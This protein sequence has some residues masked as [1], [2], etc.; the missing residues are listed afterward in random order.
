MVTSVLK[1]DREQIERA[2][3]NII[4]NAIESMSKEGKL[5]IFTEHNGAS[6]VIKI[7]D[8]GKGISEEDIIKI[9]DP[10][11]SSKRDGVG[12]GLSVCYGIIVSHGGTI[13][14][15]SKWKKGSTFALTL[16]IDQESRITQERERE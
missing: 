1:I 3:L 4:I 12:L 6:F 5:I 16:P 14:V 11:F 2:F 9:F 10:F 15:K 7:Q 13:E 8:T